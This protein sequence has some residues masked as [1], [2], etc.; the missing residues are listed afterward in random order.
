M[1]RNGMCRPD[2]TQALLRISF[3]SRKPSLPTMTKVY[4]YSKATIDGLFPPLLSLK[5][6]HS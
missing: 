3:P 1:F 4:S 2:L 6:R 5:R